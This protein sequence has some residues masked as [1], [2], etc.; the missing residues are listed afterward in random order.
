MSQLLSHF[1][2]VPTF[3]SPDQVLREAR[4]KERELQNARAPTD[5]SGFLA[6]VG[7][8]ELKHLRKLSS[9]TSLTYYMHLV[10]P[11]RLQL[12]HGLDLVVTS[13]ACDV[14]PYEHNRT[15]EECGADGDG[16]AVSFAEARQV[17]AELKRGTGGASGSGSNGAAAAPVAVAAGVS[18][19]VALPRELPFVPLPGGATEGG[20]AGAEAAAGAAAAAA[21]AAG[22]GTGPGAQGQGAGGLQLPLASTEAIGRMLRSPAEVVSAKLAEAALA[23]SAAAAASP[24][25]AA[26][27]SFYA[28][29]ASLPIPL[30]GG[31]VGANNK[32]ANT[33][34]APPNGAAASSSGG[35][36]GSGGAAAASEVVGSS[37]GAQGADPADP[38]APNTSGKATAASIA[39][40][41]TA[42][43]RSRRLGGTGPAK[44]GGSGAASSGSSSGG[45]GA[46]GM[47]PVT[48]GGMRLSPAATAFSAPPAATV[49][50]LASTDAGTALVP[51]ASSSAAS[52]TFSSSSAYSCPSEWFVVDD[53][54]SA[55]RIFVIQGSDTLDHWKLNLTFDPVVFE[56]PALGVKVH[57]G[58]YEAALVLY[59]RFLPLV[60]EHLEASPFSKVT[61]TGH[62]IGGS[63]ATLLM[64]MYRNRGVLP[65]HSIATVY[66]FGAPAV[67]CQQQQP[68]VADASSACCNGSSSNGS[69]TPASGS[70]SPRSGSPGSASASSL[71]AG[72]G[73]GA[74]GMS[75]WALGLSGFGMG[76]A[77]LAGGGSTSAP[78]STAGLA[79][80]D[81]GAVAA[82]G[83]G[84][85]FN[86]SGLGFMSV[87]DPQAV[88]MPP[89]AAQAP[90]PASAP[91]PTAGPGHN[92]HSSHSK[93]GPAA[94]KSCACG[95]DGLLTRLGLAPHV[96]RNVVMARD[97]V[98]R[99]FACDY[100][101]V[102]DILKGWGP[103]FREHCCLNRHG[104]K[105][106]YY[107]VGRMCILQPDAWHSFVGGDPEH[108]ML[109][110]GPE[111][112][113]LA[114]PED[115][116]AARAHYP[117]L[118][119]L[120]ILNAVTS[121]GHT[122]GSGGN[123]ANAA[124]N[125]AVNASGP[126]AAASGGGGGSQQPTAAAAVPSTANF[127]TALVASAA[128]RER[129]A[130][131]GGSR[132]QPRSVVEAVWEI[133]DN[134][135]PLETL[136]DPGAYLA[137]GS[138][139]R[140]HNP[141]HY[142]KALGRLTHL[143]RLAERRQHP[144]G[145]AQQ[146]QAQ[147]QAGEGGIRSMFAGRNI[148]SFGGG[149][150][151]GSGSGS[152]GR[153]GLLHQQAAS[154]GTAAD[155]VLASGAAGAAAAAW[156][157]APQLADLVSG[158]GGR[159][160]AGYEGG[161]WDSSD[162]LDL[163]LSDFMGASA[164]GAADPH[165]CR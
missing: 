165:A 112:Y 74:G 114:E 135:H 98:P 15:A 12:M 110:P 25:G 29:L 137:S 93:A 79:S 101:L 83:G 117:A 70:S 2:R 131:G 67:F 55:T 146:K 124:V 143:K 85:G 64:L 41:A 149:V 52:L 38:G 60:Y 54:A 30:A 159:A 91:A 73:S 32:A 161:V 162:G 39:A 126:S 13:R 90:S 121:N 27:E 94:A 40:M 102:A 106:L 109:P 134:P 78:S 14:R 99:A 57:R 20:E 144:H 92:S 28:G 56:E 5:V 63:M 42:E 118:S 136:A 61:F 23:A 156:G 69:S 128:Q 151:S 111:L 140:Y 133:M 58:V 4:D 142:T 119:D 37:R 160:S 65:P 31:L 122:R 141:E 153:R 147:P 43:L 107:F 105:H 103:A 9:L 33:L 158:N 36:G 46:G 82:G 24:L 10:T 96:V 123:G 104:R 35:G 129:D 87:E 18:N 125:A 150:R 148:R 152:A 45:I 48:A 19:I 115:A 11:R 1:V 3:A 155:A 16:M 22:E 80:V 88:S 62:S 21:A 138:I 49:S 66:T 116:A 34:L 72:S 47:A 81:G 7:V 53:P 157:S 84:S 68:A 8:W 154:N 97:V 95:V 139:S 50:S 120:P 108:P 51:V 75:L 164:V 113:A 132:L 77:S 71:P 127:G 59:E 6:P 163:H 130:R 86:S 44:T 76:G 145:Q 100:S 89:G 26:A 17:Y